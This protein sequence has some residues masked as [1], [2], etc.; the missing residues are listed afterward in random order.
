MLL[1]FF[2]IFLKTKVVVKNIFFHKISDY[3]SFFHI[4][5]KSSLSHLFFYFFK[6]TSHFLEN[7]ICQQNNTFFII[8]GYS[9]FF[10]HFTNV[11]SRHNFLF[12]KNTLHILRKRYFSKKIIFVK[13]NLVIY[14]FF[15][16]YREYHSFIKVLFYFITNSSD[17]LENRICFVCFRE[18]PFWSKISVFI[19]LFTY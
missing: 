13:K 9:S 6:K 15:L 16:F 5:W 11:F 4:S 10:S 3:S 8:F 2:H 12:F 1:F 18:N 7:E 17:F 19:I 14:N